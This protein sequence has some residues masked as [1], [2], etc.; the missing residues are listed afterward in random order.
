MFIITHIS[1]H[2]QVLAE[3]KRIAKPI[4]SPQEIAQHTRTSHIATSHIHAQVLAELKRIAKPIS[5]PQEIAQVASIAANGDKI[6]G[7]CVCVY[8]CTCMFGLSVRNFILRF[9][10]IFIYWYYISCVVLLRM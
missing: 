2:V 9:S 7:S 6:I 5:S 8:G 4:S 3:L 1:S 10:L